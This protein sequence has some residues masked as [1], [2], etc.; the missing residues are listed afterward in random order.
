MTRA[1]LSGLDRTSWRRRGAAQPHQL[2]AVLVGEPPI[3][4][5]SAPHIGL[6][7]ILW[8]T[9]RGLM[10]GSPLTNTFLNDYCNARDSGR[11][12]ALDRAIS[13]EAQQQSNVGFATD[14]REGF[15]KAPTK[16]PPK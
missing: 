9:V 13:G 14:R 8:A 12:G 11:L 4:G 15:G 10:M 16:M 1:I 2:I 3:G 6:A 5:S 7:E